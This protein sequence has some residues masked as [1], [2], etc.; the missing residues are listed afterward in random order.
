[1]KRVLGCALVSVLVVVGCRGRSSGAGQG[2]AAPG[3]GAPAAQAPGEPADDAAVVKEIQDAADEIA[4]NQ[5]D[6][7]AVKTEFAHLSKKL[8][9]ASRRVGSP[10]AKAALKD[11]E[12]KL[13]P[14]VG[15]CE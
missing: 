7:A 6:C 10:E 5:G 1:M 2:A 14:I 13:G 4:R 12:A 15:R 8:G 11:I 9:S 3:G